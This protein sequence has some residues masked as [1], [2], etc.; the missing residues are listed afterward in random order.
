MKIS[1]TQVAD[2]VCENF[3]HGK[4]QVEN[5]MIFKIA[6]LELEKQAVLK[7]NMELLEALE[8]VIRADMISRPM[9][10]HAAFKL[11]EKAIAKAKDE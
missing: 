6:T 7:L 3:Q 5:K 4:T 11:A 8:S 2:Y 1:K 9:S 10:S